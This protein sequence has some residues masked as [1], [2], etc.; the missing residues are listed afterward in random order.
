MALARSLAPT[1]QERYRRDLD[2]YVLPALGPRLLGQLT[3]EEIEHWLN[4]EL[5]SGLATAVEKDRLHANPCDRVRPPKVRPRT[6]VVLHWRDCV[7]LAEAHSVALAIAAGARPKAIHVRMGHSSI[8]V[9]F[10]RYGHPFPSSMT[11]L[12]THSTRDGSRPPT[13]RV[14]VIRCR[15][16]FRC[17]VGSASER[18]TARPRPPVDE[19]EGRT[20]LTRGRRRAPAAALGLRPYRVDFPVEFRLSGGHRRSAARR[21]RHPS[22]LGASALRDLRRELSSVSP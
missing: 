6:T 17:E 10:D 12:P 4:D 15:P 19:S 18:S 14:R 9:T 8:T 22:L 5:A 20:R 7:A 21:A 11:P 16:S 2:R 3:A 13:R 1:T